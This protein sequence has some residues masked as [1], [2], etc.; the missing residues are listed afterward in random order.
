MEK[1]LFEEK[2]KFNQVGLW[3]ILLLALS[4]VLYFCN[5]RG[6][7][8]LESL[9]S[10]IV[11][12]MVILLF[13]FIKL[14]TQITN[15]GIR[16]RFFPIQFQFREILWENVAEVYVREYNAIADFGGWGYR[17]RFFGKGKALTIS[18]NKGIQIY[19]NERRK[20]LI[21]T[22]HPKEVQEILE[23]LGLGKRINTT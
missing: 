7:F 15:R 4:L 21:G 3:A 14:E 8:Q 5:I 18:G 10:L 12:S 6:F 11:I 9:I 17:I 20:I 23:S 1:V 13:I 2:Q 16:Y 19:T 22:Q